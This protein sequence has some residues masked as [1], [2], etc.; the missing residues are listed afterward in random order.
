MKF[1][2]KNKLLYL[3]V[4]VASALHGGGGVKI[5]G[6]HGTMVWYSVPREP[7]KAR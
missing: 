7:H 3:E 5:C 2:L 4:L 6:Q 1:C